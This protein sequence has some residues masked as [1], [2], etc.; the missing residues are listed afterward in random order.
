MVTSEDIASVMATLGWTTDADIAGVVL[1]CIVM[2]GTDEAT[3]DGVGS[4]IE[5]TK[6]EG[7]EIKEKHFILQVM[8]YLQYVTSHSKRYIM[9]I[10]ERY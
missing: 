9:F 1:G 4:I 8:L 2:P 6:K 7:K 3:D 10:F 5:D